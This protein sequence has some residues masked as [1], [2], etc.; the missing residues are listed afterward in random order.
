[1]REVVGTKAEQTIFNFCAT[2]RQKDMPLGTVFFFDMLKFL[3]IP[4]HS[5]KA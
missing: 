2:N 3:Y 5:T 4:F 1:M